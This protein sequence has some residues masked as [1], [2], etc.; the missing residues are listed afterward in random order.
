MQ[1]S[2]DLYA[3]KRALDGEIGP[4]I[5]RTLPDGTIAGNGKITRAFLLDG[6]WR[7]QSMTVKMRK[8]EM[9]ETKKN[10]AMKYY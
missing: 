8:A 10:D 6:L 2:L 3:T 5:K 7:K 9:K 1:N 4:L